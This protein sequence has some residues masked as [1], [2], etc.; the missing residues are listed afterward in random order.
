MRLIWVLTLLILCQFSVA[1]EITYKQVHISREHIK[2]VT[3]V[4]PVWEGYTN[5]DGTG[6]YWDILRAIYEPLNIKVN[7]KN[8]PWNR[9][10]K[11]V[12]KYRTFNAIVGEYRDTQEN[13]LF[14]DYP[15]D[16]EFMSVIT[17]KGAVEPFKGLTSFTG[18]RVGWIKDYDVITEEKRDFELKEF[19]DLEQGLEMLNAGELDY[20]MDDWDE[21]AAIMAKYSLTTQ[22]YSVDE[23]REGKDI[24]A[25]FSDDNLSKELIAIYNERIPVLVKSGELAAIYKKW[26]TAVIPESVMFAGE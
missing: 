26:D 20:V 3:I 10:M 2:T 24:Y 21:I 9:A 8:V 1:E 22:E 14:P 23:L 12:S 11:M 7:T 18:K 17:K 6:V 13:V 19:R 25:A 15:I 5:G 4:A 16:V